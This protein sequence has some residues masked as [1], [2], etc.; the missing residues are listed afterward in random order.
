MKYELQIETKI[1]TAFS[2]YNHNQDGLLDALVRIEKQIE[3]PD[4]LC[5]KIYS[6][7]DGLIFECNK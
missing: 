1:Q 3:N 4:F 6:E 2:N 7:R 5:A